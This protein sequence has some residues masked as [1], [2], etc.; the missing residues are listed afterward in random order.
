MT[1]LAR[2]CAAALIAILPVCSAQTANHKSKPAP[3]ARADC[4]GAL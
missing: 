2:I 3:K 4:T 1:Q